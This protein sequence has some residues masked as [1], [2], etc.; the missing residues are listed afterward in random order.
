MIACRVHRINGITKQSW[1][2]WFFK[3]HANPMEA[4]LV[5]LLSVEHALEEIHRSKIFSAQSRW[6]MEIAHV[7]IMKCV[8]QK[9][10]ILSRILLH[11][12]WSYKC[13]LT[14]E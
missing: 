4:R 11:M 13:C 7:S 6:F 12:Y 14:S 2:W 10:Y 8:E 3:W 1:R 9:T 5:C